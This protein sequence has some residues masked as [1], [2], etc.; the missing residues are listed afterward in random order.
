ML[1]CSHLCHPI[2]FTDRAPSPPHATPFLPLSCPRPSHAQSL[3]SFPGATKFPSVYLLALQADGQLGVIP[4]P[5]PLR[6]ANLY[7]FLSEIRISRTEGAA[8]GGGGGEGGSGAAGG[9]L[10]AVAAQSDFEAVCNPAGALC[11][12]ALLDGTAEGVEAS[13]SVMAKVRLLSA[14]PHCRRPAFSR[15]L[16]AM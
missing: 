9:S 14:L 15:R 11:A 4:I 5:P 8:E 12:L 7:K 2:L 13:K 10:T 6:Y 3:A 1:D 16:G